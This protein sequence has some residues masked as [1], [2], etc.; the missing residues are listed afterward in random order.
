[1]T[2]PLCDSDTGACL[3]PDMPNA[4]SRDLQPAA[5]CFYV[6]DP[7]CS[8]C[9]GMSPEVQR[10]AA[11]CKERAL[12]FRIVMGGLRPG[13]GDAWDVNFKNFL[14][15]EWRKIASVTNQP[16]SHRLLDRADFIY[17][18]EPACR[19]VAV[20][21][22]MLGDEQLSLEF[23]SKVQRK[24]YV[25]GEDPKAAEFYRSICDECGVDFSDLFAALDH[26]DSH[27]EVAAHFRLARDLGCRSFPSIVV[28][29]GERTVQLSVGYRTFPDLQV[30]LEQ[31]LTEL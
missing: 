11:Y 12:D 5:G 25:N 7:M 14:S 9:W 21:R 17:D 18:T 3:M 13:G 30:D 10:L 24:F 31:V 4:K 16:F 27:K 20:A 15:A 29:V 26:S 6:G 19:A 28:R 8:W 22:T 1:M 23:F 2:D